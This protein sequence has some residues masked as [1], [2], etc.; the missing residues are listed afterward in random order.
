[1]GR[2]QRRG[3]IL[4]LFPPHLA[5]PIR[6]EFMGDEIESLR[7]FDLATQRSLRAVDQVTIVPL[8][9]CLTDLPPWDE[10]ARRGSAA[11]LDIGRL[12]EI[13]ECLERLIVPPGVERLLPLFCDG[14]ESFLNCLPP[15]SALVLDRPTVIEA[16]AEFATSI[17][18]G[19]Q[20]ALL[21][22][23]LVASPA[24]RYLT[25]ATVAE[26][27]QVCQRVELQ[28]LTVDLP[29]TETTDLLTGHVLGSY[30]GRRETLVS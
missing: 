16:S 20:Q 5:R 25:P 30:H 13:V 26:C 7:E 11:H 6:L 12:Q 3:G 8:R 2:L 14:L 15:E 17:E 22:Q 21:R 1:M 10:I 4:D 29:E 9:E 23:D 18:E 28:S 27:F 24:T 19:Y